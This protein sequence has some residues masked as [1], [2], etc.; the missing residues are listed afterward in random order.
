MSQV[1]DLEFIAD[2]R[3]VA[4]KAGQCDALL[5]WFDTIFREKCDREVVF[6]TGPYVSPALLALPQRSMRQVTR[7]K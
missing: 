4:K 6:T 1:A 5:T 7:G 2:F 3:V